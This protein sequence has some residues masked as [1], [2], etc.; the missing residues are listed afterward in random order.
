MQ[1]RPM[2]GGKAHIGEHVGLGF[3]PM[4][5]ASLGSLGLSW[6]ATLRHCALAA[7]APSWANAAAMKAETTR[8]LLLPAWASAL[9]IVCTRQRCQIAFISLATAALT[10]SWASEVTSLTPRSPRRRSLRRNSLPR[11][12]LSRPSAAPP[13][14]SPGVGKYEPL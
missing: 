9:R 12:A 3:V 5:P 7:S 11:S 14:Q 1:L 13:G 10:P 8:L 4:K 6:S 2:L